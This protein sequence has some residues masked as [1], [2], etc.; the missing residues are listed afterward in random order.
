MDNDSILNN[1][2]NDTHIRVYLEGEDFKMRI[3]HSKQSNRIKINGEGTLVLTHNK[4]GILM[5]EFEFYEGDPTFD[6]SNIRVESLNGNSFTQKIKLCIRIL[7]F[8]W[9]RS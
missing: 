8:I 1:I 9:K 5:E 2:R 7:K 4:Y 6:I 3:T